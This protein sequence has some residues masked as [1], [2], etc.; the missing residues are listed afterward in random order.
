MEFD[1]TKLESNYT[2]I[3]SNSTKTESNS[4]K[5]SIRNNILFFYAYYK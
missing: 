1:S 4:I 2:E 3:E 5:E